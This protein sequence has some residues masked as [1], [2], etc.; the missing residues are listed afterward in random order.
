MHH[1][2]YDQLS[3]SYERILKYAEEHGHAIRR[4]T[5]EVYHKGP[6]MIFKGNPKKYLTEIQMMLDSA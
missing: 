1:G 2:P 6:G 3:S 5:R 4:P